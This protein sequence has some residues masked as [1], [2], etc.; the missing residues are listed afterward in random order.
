MKTPPQHFKSTK[1]N[2]RR[3]EKSIE[4]AKAAK[5]KEAALI[6]KWQAK[7]D[8]DRLKAQK[9]AQSAA[10]AY[11]KKNPATPAA[12]SAAKPA[13]PTPPAPAKP[14]APAPVPAA[15]VQP[16]PAA[17]VED[18]DEDDLPEKRR[19]GV[20]FT[21]AGII[22]LLIAV[23]VTLWQFGFLDKLLQ[24]PVNVPTTSASVTSQ[25]EATPTE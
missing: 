14:T 19:G 13:A 21:I 9:A 8:K 24:K 22:F 2:P 7:A 3:L 6:A 5:E 17:P 10:D 16:K 25:A 23:L 12:P 15:P 11:F 1:L 4:A 20:F 18:Y